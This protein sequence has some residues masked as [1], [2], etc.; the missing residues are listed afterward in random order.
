ML[1]GYSVLQE[2]NIF[3]LVNSF[4]GGFDQMYSFIKAN[5]QI[6]NINYDFNSNPN[7]VVY[8]DNSILPNTPS[9]IPVLE[10]TEPSNVATLKAQELQNI[11]DI[12]AMSY[13]NFDLMYKL[14]QDNIILKN[15][16]DSILGVNFTYD[17]SLVH[18]DIIYGY[19]NRNNIV[20]G[21]GGITVPND[22]CTH[23]YVEKG[24]VVCGYVE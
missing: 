8:Y 4:Y 10:S 7:T 5:P 3:D 6:E 18:D 23:I 17:K 22:L 21:T 11:F 13:G 20:I 24:Y 16:N 12:C 19:F 9:E 2:Q 14:I 15:I 1:T